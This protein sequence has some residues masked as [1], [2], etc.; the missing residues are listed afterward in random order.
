MWITF[1]GHFTKELARARG[2]CREMVLLIATLAACEDK[3]AL[4]HRLRLFSS[5][6]DSSLHWCGGSWILTRSQ[7]THLRALQGNMLHRMV[8]VP[9]LMENAG[10]HMMR[11]G[12]L[13]RKLPHGNEILFASYFSESGH[14][15]RKAVIDLTR[16]TSRLFA[17]QKLGVA[18]ELEQKRWGL[19][20]TVD[21]SGPGGEWHRTVGLGLASSR[22]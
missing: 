21:F 8:Y 13:Q 9:E 22:K 7:R 14:V 1:D 11:W 10:S 19:N 20:V 4:K 12:R 18:S 6:V 2:E 3:V 5:C 16:E 17:H 15:A